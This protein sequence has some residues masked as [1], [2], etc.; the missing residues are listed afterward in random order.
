MG[1]RRLVIDPSAAGSRGDAFSIQSSPQGDPIHPCPY[2]LRSKT[3][4]PVEECLA[5]RGCHP[6]LRPFPGA[7]DRT[8][9]HAISA[10]E[11][12]QLAR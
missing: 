8:A 6:Q 4:E 3:D 5:V 12:D 11:S 9:W 2:P 10:D 7:T 1:D